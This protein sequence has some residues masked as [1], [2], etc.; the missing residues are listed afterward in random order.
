L[1][2]VLCAQWLARYDVEM[3]RLCKQGIRTYGAYDQPF[4]ENRFEI[5]FLRKTLSSF[6]FE[7]YAE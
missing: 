7:N 4:V 5:S 3:A 1:C 6:I 2:A